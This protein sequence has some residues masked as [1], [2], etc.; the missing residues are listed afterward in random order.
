MPLSATLILGPIRDIHKGQKSA[1]GN[2][3]GDVRLSLLTSLESTMREIRRKE[4]T[5]VPNVPCELCG[6]P[7]DLDN[8]RTLQLRHLLPG[9]GSGLAALYG[10]LSTEDLYR[11]FF[12]AGLPPLRWFNEWAGIGERGGF[13]LVVTSTDNGTDTLIG[14]AGYALLCDGDGELGMA[15]DPQQRGWLGPWLLDSLLRHANERGVPNIQALFLSSNRQM[16]AMTKSRGTASVGSADWSTIRVS[17]STEARVPSWPG[18][19]SGDAPHERPRLLV[20]SDR[21]RWGGAEEAIRQGFDV[22]TCRGPGSRR[23]GSRD[24]CP[25]LRGESCPLVDGADV[26][27]QVLDPADPSSAE[28]LS[29]GLVA[30]SGLRLIDGFSPDPIAGRQPGRQ[31]RRSDAEILT[32]LFADP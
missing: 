24:G 25:L 3:S 12:T 26:V 22:M 6:E 28:L 13:G 27:I 19:R 18:D 17:M 23:S 31:R 32:E 11:R 4:V 30:H 7:V 2:L 21:A 1:S 9:D 29:R 5:L 14:E 20:E 8:H 15:I 16:A 10:R